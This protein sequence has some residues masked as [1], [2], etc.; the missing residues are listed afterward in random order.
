M[1]LTVTF[2][3][4]TITLKTPNEKPTEQTLY[5]ILLL[6]N[7]FQEIRILPAGEEC[8]ILRI[9][10]QMGIMTAPFLQRFHCTT[11]AKLL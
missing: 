6:W 4:F 5:T 7:L 2:R 8:I 10:T 3:N 11:N 9:A 1:K